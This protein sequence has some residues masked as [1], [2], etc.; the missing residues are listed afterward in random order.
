MVH[1][2]SKGEVVGVVANAAPTTLSPRA[3]GEPAR[4]VLEL[5]SGRAAE[6]G[7]EKGVKMSVTGLPASQSP[8]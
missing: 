3:T 4:Y 6:V 2:N 1:I 5:T 7:I 8:Q